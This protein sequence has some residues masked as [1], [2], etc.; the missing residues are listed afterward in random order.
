MAAG[1]IRQPA[2]VVEKLKIILEK[3]N[4]QKIKT[5]FAVVIMPDD[6]IYSQVVSIPKV[7]RKKIY[8]ALL[9]QLP[10]LIPMKEDD[11]Y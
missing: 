8:E 10:N 2:V 9:F 4:P 1:I 3:K 11:I 6:Q 7:E 5:N